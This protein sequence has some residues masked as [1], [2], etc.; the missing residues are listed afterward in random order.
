MADD[1]DDSMLGELI[2][3]V[4]WP[5]VAAIALVLAGVIAIC[6]ICGWAPGW[7]ES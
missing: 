5:K 2:G 1:G 6:A 4:T 7:S 3:P